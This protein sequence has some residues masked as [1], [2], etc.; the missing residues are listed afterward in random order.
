M[1]SSLIMRGAFCFVLLALVGVKVNFNSVVHPKTPLVGRWPRFF[2][3][4]PIEVSHVDQDNLITCIR[5][6]D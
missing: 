3:P 2:R 1:G 5:R 6:Y 4:Y